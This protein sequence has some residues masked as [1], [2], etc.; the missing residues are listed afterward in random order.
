MKLRAV[1]VALAAVAVVAVVVIGWTVFRPDAQE[2]PASALPLPEGA[3]E[4]TVE[5]VYDG[6][7]LRA[8]STGGGFPV[9]EVEVRLI[10]ID[11]PEGTPTPECG[12]DEA[13]AQLRRLLPQ[14]ARFWAVHDAEATDRY[15]RQLAYVWTDDGRFVNGILVAGGFAQTLTVP[16]NTAHAD[17]LATAEAEARTAAAGLWAACP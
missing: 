1:L 3:V 9:G 13:R 6:D 12:A 17:L 5:H 11:A 4:L 14:G 16:P 15:D 2:T 7:S 10:G 8:M